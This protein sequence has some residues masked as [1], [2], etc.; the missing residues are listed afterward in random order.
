MSNKKHRSKKF[1]TGICNTITNS[2]DWRFFFF[3]LDV[4]QVHNRNRIT[5]LYLD[6]DLDFLE[7]KTGS[8]GYHYLSPTLI[9]KS[10]WKEMMNKV[11]DLNTKCPM[12]TLRI[13]PNK[14]PN[15]KFSWYRF[16]FYYNNDQL[17]SYEMSNYLNKLFGSKFKG[18]IS[19][20]L[21]IVRYPLPHSVIIA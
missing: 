3:E 6:N 9:S 4:D 21:K 10:E 20:Q 1:T 17:N 12:T 13:Q 14:H 7:H 19:T 5:K 18:K 15:E 2:K 11:K 16:D 8:G